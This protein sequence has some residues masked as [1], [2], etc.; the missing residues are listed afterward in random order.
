MT[1]TQS[2]S[3][4][5]EGSSLQCALAHPFGPVKWW[6]RPAGSPFFIAMAYSNEAFKSS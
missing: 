2:V 6:Y 3:Y 4:D 5:L 1:S